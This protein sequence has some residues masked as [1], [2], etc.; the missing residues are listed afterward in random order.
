MSGRREGGML[1]RTHNGL[2]SR[3]EAAR[4]ARLAN[5]SFF[6]NTP[7]RYSIVIRCNTC[8]G[9]ISLQSVLSSR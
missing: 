4:S 6:P 3:G 7:F 9:P 5:L 2:L 8:N 1:H